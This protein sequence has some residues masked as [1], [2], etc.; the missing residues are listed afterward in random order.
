MARHSN[1]TGQSLC[2]VNSSSRAHIFLVDR[3]NPTTLGRALQR[4]NNLLRKLGS[5]CVSNFFSNYTAS[6]GILLG[7]KRS[8]FFFFSQHP[9]F[10]CALLQVMRK[11]GP[12]LFKVSL[13]F[14]AVGYDN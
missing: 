7:L 12:T 9:V 4:E 11:L 6:E 1:R 5:W 3:K 13:F 8:F 2:K 14:H 10:G